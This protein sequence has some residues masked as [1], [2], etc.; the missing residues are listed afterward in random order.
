MNGIRLTKL[1]DIFYEDSNYEGV[2]KDSIRNFLNNFCEYTDVEVEKFINTMKY[3]LIGN[4]IIV[5]I[6]ELEEF[7]TNVTLN[8][9]PKEMIKLYDKED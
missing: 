4:Q 6:P 9:F 5:T 1:T 2:I 8:E 7:R 3:E